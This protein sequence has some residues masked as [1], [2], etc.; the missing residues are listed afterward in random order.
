MYSCKTEEIT[1][2]KGYKYHILKKKKPLLVNDFIDGLK[3][4]AGFRAY[5]NNLLAECPF[6]AFFWEVKPIIKKDLRQVFEFVLV[7]NHTLALAKPD[8]HA[9]AEHF[10]RSGMYATSFFNLGGDAL[11]VAPMPVTDVN[12]YTHLAT[13]IRRAPAEQT[14]AFWQLAGQKYEQQLSE[15]PLWL[16]TSGLGVYW[17]HLRLDSVPKYYSYHPYRIFNQ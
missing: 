15:L 5:F 10:T 13:F 3:N 11:L 14:N 6:K 1:D 9:F 4:D 16:S 17:L 7:E 2:P 12:S 8:T